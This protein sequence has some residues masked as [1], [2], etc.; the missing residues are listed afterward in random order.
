MKTGIS[1]SYG[2]DN[3]LFGPCGI[4]LVR[5]CPSAPA[6][7]SP[8]ESLQ[9]LAG[10]NSLICSLLTILVLSFYVICCNFPSLSLGNLVF[11]TIFLQLE[12][13]LATRLKWL[14]KKIG[15]LYIKELKEYDHT[16]D[17]I[18]RLL[19]Q[20]LGVQPPPGSARSIMPTAAPYRQD[21]YSTPYSKDPYATPYA[22]GYATRAPRQDGD[23]WQPYIFD[24]GVGN[25]KG[26]NCCMFLVLL[27]S[28]SCVTS[29]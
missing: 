11:K 4:N 14:K 16:R 26:K 9:R 22:E 7:S 1:F 29:Q 24:T 27:C 19:S 6:L 23:A 8:T 18:D 3:Y 20:G 21:P 2:A 25:R 12:A 10:R 13:V 15:E 5:L 28:L 17:R